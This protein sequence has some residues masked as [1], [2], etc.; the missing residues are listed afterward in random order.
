MQIGRVQPLLSLPATPAARRGAA[1]AEP[2][3]SAHL[4]LLAYKGAR[5]PDLNPILQGPDRQAAVNQAETELEKWVEHNIPPADPSEKPF[6]TG[7]ARWMARDM[8]DQAR[9]EWQRGALDDYRAAV[10]LWDNEEGKLSAL[11]GEQGE[12]EKAVGLFRMLEGFLGDVRFRTRLASFLQSHDGRPATAAELFHALGLEDHELDGWLDNPGFPMVHARLEGNKVKL[13]Q[14]QM[15]LYPGQPESQAL[16]SVPIRIRYKD[17]DKVREYK[18]ILKSREDEI[19]LPAQGRLDWIYPNGGGKGY[20]R[21]DVAPPPGELGKLRPTERMAVISNQWRL[22]RHGTA[23]V[24]AFLNQL[25]ATRQD[26]ELSRSA[27]LATELQFQRPLVP[28]ADQAA[29]NSF[30]IDQLGPTLERLGTE[31]RPDEPMHEAEVRG[32]VLRLLAYAGQPQALEAARQL[33]RRYLAGEAGVTPAQAAMSDDPAVADRLLAE[34]AERKGDFARDIYYELAFNPGQA[35][36]V[37]AFGLEHPDQDQALTL[38]AWFNPEKTAALMQSHWDKLPLPSM[39]G[40]L[41]ISPARDQVDR[42]VGER[43]SEEVRQAW[44]QAKNAPGQ[45]QTLVDLPRQLSAWLRARSQPQAGEWN[46]A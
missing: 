37:A 2:S 23:P 29:F 8:V 34:A 32:R 10:N 27:L 31:P 21:T 28:L 36:K 40:A 46:L 42:L 13:S 16:W 3:E 4:S 45:S 44:E 18:T 39:L 41:V 22:V 26:P 35:D 9:P 12:P 17:G 5:W 25:E 14:E 1:A 15:V 19:T 43:G 30:Q 20:Y 7:L 38:Y 24:S 33:G 6:W 11:R